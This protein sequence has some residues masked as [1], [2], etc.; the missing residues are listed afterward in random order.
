MP[1]YFFFFGKF[2]L[3]K[4]AGRCPGGFHVDFEIFLAEGLYFVEM[5]LFSLSPT[6]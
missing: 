1:G 2:L 3:Y 6:I 5:I 4:H